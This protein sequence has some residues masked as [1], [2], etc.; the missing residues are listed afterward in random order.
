[1]GIM[2]SEALASV[3][4]VSAELL[5]DDD[6]SAFP[7][8]QGY[9][10]IET[11]LDRLFAEHRAKK[12]KIEAFA[13]L[14]SEKSGGILHY[15]VE[16]SNVDEHDRRAYCVA[17]SFEAEPAVKALDAEYWQ[18]AI[19]LTDVL[20]LM[21]AALRHEWSDQIR[22]HK[23]P[24]FEPATVRET[25]TAL[26]ADRGKFFAQR[27]DGIFRALS[28][29]HV[30]NSPSGFNKRMI[31]EYVV[32]HLGYVE[33]RKSDF[34]H[35][36]RVV[37]ARFHGRE[38]DVSYA[39]S[40]DIQG[41]VRD[42]EYGVW[43]RF[44]GGVF[45]LKVFKKGT[46]H[47]EVHPLI[48][49]RLNQLLASLYPS[50]IAT[51]HRRKSAAQPKDF[52]LDHRLVSAGTIRYLHSVRFE[53]GGRQMWSNENPSKETQEVLEAIGGA[54]IRPR[55]F[56]FDYDVKRVVDELRRTGLVPDELSHQF[57]PTR[58]ALALQA[59]DWA[60]IAEGERV[61]EP[62]AGRGGIAL[63]VTTGELTCVEVSPFN[64]AIL[65]GHGLNAI[66]ADFLAWESA[67]L[68]DVV[69][70]NPP[71]SGGRARLHVVKAASLLSPGG[72]LVAVMPASAKG[73]EVVPGLRHQWSDIY[74]NQFAGTGV[75][76]VLLKLSQS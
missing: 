12:L 24:A 7:G 1:M 56:E 16:A 29:S 33:S 73:K 34:I 40:R 45:R 27:I 11:P 66:C 61:L 43:K 70:M 31:L 74:E 63:H 10:A 54:M 64:V 37:I 18:K 19:T 20:E 9:L 39:T 75:S 72:R 25:L 42:G 60:E 36:L 48:A 68:Y 62:S 47:L 22:Q 46:A 58:E 38:C 5:L 52:A 35:D 71:F 8:G 14:A 2:E 26:L 57:Y 55:C 50:A 15:F 4:T 67:S 51:E 41:I 53:A 59:V 21:P 49:Y 69:V 76:V 32:D 17:P 28:R 30:T 6:S 65:K 44:D 23:T 3:G 13:E